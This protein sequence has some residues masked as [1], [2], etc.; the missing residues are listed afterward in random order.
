MTTE[1]GPVLN[2]VK[3]AFAPVTE[4]FTKLQNI[5][6]PEAAREF[7]KKQNRDRQGASRR[8]L[9]RFGK[10][11]RCD[12]NRRCRFG[13][14]GRQDQ[15]QHPAGA[16]SGRGSVLRRHR[17]AGFG[18]VDQ[19]SGYDPVG[20][21]PCARRSVRHAG[22]GHHRISRQARRRRCQDRAGQ[23]LQGLAQDR[24]IAYLLTNCLF[25]ARFGGPS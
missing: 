10:S 23:L 25:E 3:E 2:S 24:L 15:P 12:R 16:L 21:G 5:E 7:V 22:E 6:V 20:P 17:Q 18:Q 8:P 19:R 11:D 13:H 1:R 14:R 4:A 9:C